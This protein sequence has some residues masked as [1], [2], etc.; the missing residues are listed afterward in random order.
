MIVLVPTICILIRRVRLEFRFLR[1][2]NNIMDG[3]RFRKCAPGCCCRYSRWPHKWPII[4]ALK[5]SILLPT[6]HF[7]ADHFSGKVFFRFLVFR[8]RSFQRSFCWKYFSNW[9]AI[10]LVFFFLTRNADHFQ[11]I[12]FNEGFVSVACFLRLFQLDIYTI[13]IGW[14]QNRVF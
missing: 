6:D 13:L 8:C 2:G 4:F 7:G 11:T 1:P 3:G 5:N 9:A 14:K 12:I 10:I